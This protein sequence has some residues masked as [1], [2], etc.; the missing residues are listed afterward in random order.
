MKS[1]IMVAALGGIF[2]LSSCEKCLT[3]DYG[4][5]EQEFCSKDKDE[6]DAFE[7]ACG[8]AGGDIK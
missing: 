7:T 4:T 6:R 5:T 2:F 8:F 1:L 3:C